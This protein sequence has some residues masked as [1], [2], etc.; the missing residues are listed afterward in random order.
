MK[1]F[2]WF[3]LSF[4]AMVGIVSACSGEVGGGPATADGGSSEGGSG[5][6]A[7]PDAAAHVDGGVTPTIDSGTTPIP[8]DSGAASMCTRSPSQDATCQAFWS[9]HGVAA[10][11]AWDCPDFSATSA[12]RQSKPGGECDST[13]S[14][15]WNGYCC[16]L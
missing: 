11:E 6:G 7:A 16:T 15:G 1:S 9:R 3:G 2:S 5:D 13:A 8:M 12:L 14:G 4:V 10:N